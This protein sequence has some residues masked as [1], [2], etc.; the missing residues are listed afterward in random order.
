VRVIVTGSAGFV[1]T[2]VVRALEERGDEPIGLDLVDG[3]DLADSYRTHYLQGDAIIHLAATCSTSGSV[4]DPS[5]TF[6]NTVQTAANI[7]EAARQQGIPVLITSSVKARD[8]R[9]P[10]GAA[11]RM[12]ELWATEYREAYKLPIVINRP[13]T[14]YGPGQEGSAES[15]WVAWFL[16]A[17]R[18]AQPV[19]LYGDGRQTRDLLHVSDYVALLLAQL[20]NVE[21]YDGRIWDVGGGWPNAVTVKELAD[22]LGLDYSQEAPRYGDAEVYVGI[23]DAPAWSPKVRWFDS[24]TLGAFR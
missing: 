9:T 2:H 7:L 21:S 10:Y 1:G 24:E 14:I 12:V 19:K 18:T 11:K 3:C 15:G 16:E 4:R 17:K 23:N 13:G 20:D 22:Y 6:R 8:G 5:T